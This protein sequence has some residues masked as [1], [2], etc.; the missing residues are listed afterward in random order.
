MFD[1]I[2]SS[3]EN[4]VPYIVRLKEKFPLKGSTINYQFCGYLVNITMR[5]MYFELNG[6]RMMVIISHNDIDYM[7]PSKVHFEL[8]TKKSTLYS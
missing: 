4:N 6:S 3:Y 8:Y 1:K 2:K 7:A 5:K